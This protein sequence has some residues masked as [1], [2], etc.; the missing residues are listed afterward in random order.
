MSSKNLCDVN[1]KRHIP[2]VLNETPVPDHGVQRLDVARQI[3]VEHQVVP[4]LLQHLQA[5]SVLALVK[6]ED[7]LK[8]I[9]IYKINIV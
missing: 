3:H 1:V 2:E 8:Q 5:L 9:K 4:D 7:Y 6:V